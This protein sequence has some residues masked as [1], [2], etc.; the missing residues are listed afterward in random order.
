MAFFINLQ[1]ISKEKPTC[2]NNFAHRCIFIQR[3]G[4][5]KEALSPGNAT[6]RKHREDLIVT[7]IF[8]RPINRSTFC[9][10]WESSAGSCAVESRCTRPRTCN[11]LDATIFYAGKILCPLWTS[12]DIS[13]RVTTRSIFSLSYVGFAQ[14]PRRG[15]LLTSFPSFPRMNT[16]HSMKNVK[17]SVM[18]PKVSYSLNSTGWR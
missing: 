1:G 6:D 16:E 11:R 14:C 3:L 15:S 12:I 4:T 8:T 9:Q 7:R 10:S 2:T 17:A 13:M 5:T 18:I